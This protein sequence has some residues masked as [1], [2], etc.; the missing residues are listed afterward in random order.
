[1]SNRLAGKIAIVTGGGQGIGQAIAYA[2]ARETANVVIVD[3]N[4]ASGEATAKQIRRSGGNSIFVQADV[5]VPGN[6]DAMASK[7]ISTYGRIDVLVANAGINVFHEPMETS[8]EEWRRCFSVDLDGMW[9]SARAVLPQ[10]RAQSSGS[11]IMMASCHAFQ[12]VPNCF[13]YPVA[14]H[15]VVGLVR[16]LGVQYGPEGIRVNGIAPSYI[17][18]EPVREYWDSFQNPEAERQRARDLHPYRHIGTPDEVAMT[19]VF[20]ASDEAPFINAAIIPLD[21]GR[22][23]V[24]HD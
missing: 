24:Y 15:A 8:D 21:G 20:L 2:F 10:M 7:T 22:S 16:A 13:P 5:T 4:Q 17:E 12:I 14:K 3:C 23:A 18:T 11:I 1:V 19:A 9:S 6:L